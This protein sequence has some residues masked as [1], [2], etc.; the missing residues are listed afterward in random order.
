M[1]LILFSSKKGA[2]K[3]VADLIN[4]R[5]ENSRTVNINKETPNLN[6]Y[7]NIYIGTPIYIGMINKKIK[8]FISENK[9]LLIRKNIKVFLVGMNETE[10][11][12]VITNNFPDGISSKANIVH[13][14]GAYYFEK[15]NFLQKIVVKKITGITKTTESFKYDVINDL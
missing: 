5:L 4:D 13:V 14:G 10:I 6:D 8:K 12:N 11:D 2:T 3:K 15:L 7:E 9:E 1:D